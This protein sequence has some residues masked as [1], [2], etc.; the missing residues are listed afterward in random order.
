MIGWPTINIH[1]KT[2]NQIMDVHPV[3]GKQADIQWSE[4][5]PI[6]NS[7]MFLIFRLVALFHCYRRSS[8]H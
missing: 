4:G 3:V 8:V 6:M 2:T 7:Q 1:D 5:V